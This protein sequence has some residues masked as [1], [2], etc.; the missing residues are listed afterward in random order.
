VDYVN[1]LNTTKS[2]KPGVFFPAFPKK[3]DGYLP[4]DFLRYQQ[5]FL[6]KTESNLMPVVVFKKG[7]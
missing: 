4:T 5:P 6:W 1:N 3:I 2:G 7:F